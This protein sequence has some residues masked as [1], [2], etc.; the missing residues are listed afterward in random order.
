MLNPRRL[1]NRCSVTVPA[2]PQEY[3]VIRVTAT[4]AG[5]TRRL[6]G[7]GLCEPGHLAAMIYWD[8]VHSNVRL[9]NTHESLLHCDEDSRLFVRPT[10]WD[11]VQACLRGLW[12]PR[13]ERVIRDA[14][15]IIDGVR[16]ARLFPRDIGTRTCLIP[17]S[18]SKTAHL[19][20]QCSVS[21]EGAG[22][23]TPTVTFT[24]SW[25]H[26]TGGTNRHSWGIVFRNGQPQV[27]F[28][29]GPRPPQLPG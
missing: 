14:A 20:G 21:V 17:V 24:E 19:R 16:V 4:A 25:P 18:G 7:P 27:A 12:T 11:S 22:S 2:A 8:A 10:P 28:Q 9:L 29:S 15:T 13:S 3:D 1:P 6:S 5:K 23:A 26:A